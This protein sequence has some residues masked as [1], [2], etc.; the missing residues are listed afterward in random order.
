MM[1]ETC[2]VVDQFCISPANLRPIVP[3]RGV[4]FRCG[5]PVCHKC[6]TKRKYLD[7]GKVR[8]CNNCQEEIDG[9]DNRIMARLIR[10]AK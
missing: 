9:N 3:I 4:C 6:S 2:S 1:A 8:L 10:M 7:H 5:L